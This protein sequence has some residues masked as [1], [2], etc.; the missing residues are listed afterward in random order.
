METYISKK[1]FCQ[2]A[3]ELFREFKGQRPR[4]YLGYWCYEKPTLS[5]DNEADVPMKYLRYKKNG[6]EMAITK[7]SNGIY[8][9]VSLEFIDGQIVY[10]YFREDVQ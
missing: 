10:K 3:V 9:G 2:A 5:M 7:E 8:E 1:N 6:P 4:K